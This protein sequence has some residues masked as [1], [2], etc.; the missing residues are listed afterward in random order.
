[1][2]CSPRSGAANGSPGVSLSWMCRPTTRCGPKRDAPAPRCSR[3]PHPAPAAHLRI[4]LDQRR[5]HVGCA[6]PLEPVRRWALAKRRFHASLQLR[7][8]LVAREAAS[9]ARIIGELFEPHRPATRGQNFWSMPTIITQ[10]PSAHS[11]WPMIGA[12]R[13]SARVPRRSAGS[14][15]SPGACNAIWVPSS[16][17]STFWPRPVR[18]RAKSAVMIPKAKFIAPDWSATP[19]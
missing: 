16:D 2:A 6:Q 13:N 1:M 15:G 7:A 12:A 3:S 17:T 9:K 10:R 19:G 5:R 14:G 4:V 18:S 11:K 8:V